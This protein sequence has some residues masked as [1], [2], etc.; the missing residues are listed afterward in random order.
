MHLPNGALLENHLVEDLN[1]VIILQQVQNRIWN[2]VE[3][4]GFSPSSSLTPLPRKLFRFGGLWVALLVHECPVR[5][6]S[7]ATLCM[8]FDVMNFS[9]GPNYI[10]SH[11]AFGHDSKSTRAPTPQTAVEGPAIATPLFPAF[12][13]R[14][15]H[16]VAGSTRLDH[17]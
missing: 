12:S 5:Q 7:W 6:R 14:K 15:I 9:F 3:T 11:I 4:R 13:Q 8:F 17:Y 10:F 16:G 2:S 1:F